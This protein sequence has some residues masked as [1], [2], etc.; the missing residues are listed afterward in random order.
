MH[1]TEHK[2]YPMLM[3]VYFL[4]IMDF[5]YELDVNWNCKKCDFCCKMQK[6]AV[7]VSH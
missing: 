5:F 4:T 6:K 1:I 7:L 3:I 2:I